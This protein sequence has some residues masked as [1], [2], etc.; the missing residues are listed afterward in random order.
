ML[1]RD[2]PRPTRKFHD[3]ERERRTFQIGSRC[4]EDKEIAAGRRRNRLAS[5]LS[6]CFENHNDRVV[7]SVLN[8]FWFRQ[9]GGEQWKT[10]F[11]T[12]QWSLCA[13]R[14]RCFVPWKAGDCLLKQR[15]GTTKRWKKS[16]TVRSNAMM[17]RRPAHSLTQ[18]CFAMHAMVADCWRVE[19]V[20]KNRRPWR[21][22]PPEKRW[23]PA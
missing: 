16:R 10:S 6:N 5:Q 15:C 7:K 18:R 13:V 17:P 4:A 11:A 9:V 12:G 14:A 2:N 8:K 22:D 19:T 1:V 3:Q 20:C 23:N 21:L